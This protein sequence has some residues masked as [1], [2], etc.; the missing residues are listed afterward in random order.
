MGTLPTLLIL[1]AIGPAIIAAGATGKPSSG[2][3]VF[4]IT[5]AVA[6]YL[7]G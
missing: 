1:L 5:L 6:W 3:G 2:I 7:L 4:A